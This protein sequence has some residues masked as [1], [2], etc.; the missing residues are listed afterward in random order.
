ME[1]GS[2]LQVLP[3]QW[4]LRAFPRI[5]KLRVDF[6]PAKSNALLLMRF[7]HPRHIASQIQELELYD[8]SWPS[9]MTVRLISQGFHGIRVLKLSQ[10]LIW[11]NLCNI[12][13]FATFRDHPPAE[14]VYDK[15]VGLSVRQLR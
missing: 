13:R 6:D 1:L 10:D 2:D 5:R 8:I 15:F 3:V 12:C 14:I 7:D 11:C 9:P 4:N